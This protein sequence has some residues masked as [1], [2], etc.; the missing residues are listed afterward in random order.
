MQFLNFNNMEISVEKMR[1]LVF[2]VKFGT[3]ILDYF[4]SS[5]VEISEIIKKTPPCKNAV[6]RQYYKNY[7]VS[8]A[9][10]EGLSL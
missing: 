2:S 6:S 9:R 1:I 4:L 3:L 7:S 5:S 8:K 10:W